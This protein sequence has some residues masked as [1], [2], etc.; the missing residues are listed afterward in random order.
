MKKDITP[1]KCKRIAELLTITVLCASPVIGI[2]DR[3]YAIEPTEIIEHE[4]IMEEKPVHILTDK[5]LSKLY[6]CKEDPNTDTCLVVSVEDAEILMKIAVLEDH[7]DEISQAYVMSIIMNRVNSPDYPNTIRQVV[8]QD[9]QFLKLTDERYMN[10]VPDVNSH[11]ALAMIEG[12]Q[13]ETD[14]FFYEAKWVKNSWASRHREVAL[15]YGGSRF[16]K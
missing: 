5:E 9:G 12:R 13:V 1:Y 3:T 15:E 8:E 14:F 11:L 16:Y 6:S 10:A 4:K 2:H 7:T